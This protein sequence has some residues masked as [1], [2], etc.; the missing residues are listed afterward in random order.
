M[1]ANLVE[2]KRNCIQVLALGRLMRIGR[3]SEDIIVRRRDSGSNG[4]ISA[5]NGAEVSIE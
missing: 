4:N 2:K 5:A 1:G 3:L